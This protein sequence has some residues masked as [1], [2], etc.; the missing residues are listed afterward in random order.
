MANEGIMAL[1]QGQQ[2]QG[3]GP[4]MNAL[5][6]AAP[7]AGA[8]KD[9]GKTLQELDPQMTAQYKAA[10]APVL[11]QMQLTPEQIRMMIQ[12]FDY[13]SEHRDE[14]PQLLAELVQK[15]VLQQGDL[16]EQFDATLMAVLNWC[17]MNCRIKRRLRMSKA[18]ERCHRAKASR[19]ARRS[20]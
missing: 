7:R 8:Y 9:L 14:Y 10:I 20:R 1:P 17:C 6:K 19:N 3:N 18:L 16:P 5:N 13:L 4:N 12:L 2:M 11:Q 15:G